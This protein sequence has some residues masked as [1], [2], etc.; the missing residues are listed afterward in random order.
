MGT[1]NSIEI[2]GFVHCLFSFVVVKLA[3]AVKICSLSPWNFLIL[4]KIEAL[5]GSYFPLP[6]PAEKTLTLAVLVGT[7]ILITTLLA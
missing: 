3:T 1:W 6:F 7:G 5:S 2:G 4:Q